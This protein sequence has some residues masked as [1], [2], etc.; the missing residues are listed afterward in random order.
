MIE[1]TRSEIICQG[2][3]REIKRHEENGRRLPCPVCGSTARNF[4]DKVKCHMGVAQRR[5]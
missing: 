2:C 5:I 1:T 4:R 3:L